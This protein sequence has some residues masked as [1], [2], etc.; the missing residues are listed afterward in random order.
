[1]DKNPTGN[2]HYRTPNTAIAAYLFSEGF[3]LVDVI[4]EP[5]SYKPKDYEAVFLFENDPKIPDCIR[6]WQTGQAIGNLGVFLDNYR[7]MV[8][9]AKT[10]VTIARL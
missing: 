10:A 1:M 4:V 5:H 3:A 8:R 6:L 7:K 2:N 9:R